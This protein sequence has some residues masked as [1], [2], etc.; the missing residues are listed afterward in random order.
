MLAKRR[1]SLFLVVLIVVASDACL[2]RPAVNA[3]YIRTEDADGVLLRLSNTTDLAHLSDDA[4]FAEDLAIR[5]ADVRKGHRSGHFET[6]AEYGRTRDA[7]IAALFAVIADEHGVAPAQVRSA[8]TRRP[9]AL[10]LVVFSF[11]FCTLRLDCVRNRA[12]DDRGV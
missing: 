12:M 4:T 9:A 1:L 3:G 8:L 6:T 7:C 11:I 2:H 10:D 5:Y